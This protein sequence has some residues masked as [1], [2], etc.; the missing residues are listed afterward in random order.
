[1]ENPI[2]GALHPGKLVMKLLEKC[3]NLGK[4]FLFGT[5]I[6]EIKEEENAVQ[7][8]TEK[9]QL[10]AERTVIATNTFAKDLIPTFDLIPVRG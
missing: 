2:E 1:M 9:F 6:L 3:Q 7:L 8:R 4:E 5:S 10:H